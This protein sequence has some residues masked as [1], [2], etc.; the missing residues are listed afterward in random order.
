MPTT[1]RR[2]ALLCHLDKDIGFCRLGIVSE[3]TRSATLADNTPEDLSDLGRTGNPALLIRRT[4]HSKIYVA[5]VCLLC[6]RQAAIRL[7]M[8][9]EVLAEMNIAIRSGSIETEARARCGRRSLRPIG[10]LLRISRPRCTSKNGDLSQR[11]VYAL[12][13]EESSTDSNAPVRAAVLHRPIRIPAGRP[14]PEMFAT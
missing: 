8:L 5:I 1:E 10:P 4:K 2:F 12:Q 13:N 7:R 11:M 6:S 3:P 14:C 9:T